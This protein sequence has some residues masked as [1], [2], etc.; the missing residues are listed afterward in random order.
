MASAA[1]IGGATLA[2]AYIQSEAAKSAAN[3]GASAAAEQQRLELEWRNKEVERLT[4]ELGV[5]RDEATRIVNAQWEETQELLNPYV[6]GGMDAF[7]RQMALSGAMGGEAQ[8][9]AYDQYKE[10]PGVAFQRE[11]GM[12]GLES[13]LSARGGLGGGSRL[14]A[15]S[16]FN[17]GIAMQDFNNQWNR[18]SGLSAMGQGAATNLASMGQQ[19][20]Q[21]LAGFEFGAVASGPGMP[22]SQAANIGQI[23]AQNIM[24]Q[25]NIQA[26]TMQQLASLYGY[27][28]GGG[29]G[30]SAQP[31]ATAPIQTTT[32]S[33]APTTYNPYGLTPGM[34]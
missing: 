11:Q 23:Q 10:S 8:Q 24:N 29:F 25:G 12:R 34:A 1:V 2:A 28:Q 15:L 19:T 3:T 33:A 21:S 31:N 30:S 6:E 16:E 14:K 22:Q 20:A 27:Y 13:G 4:T 9:A 26:N 18:L 17:Q 7:K 32:P 5:A